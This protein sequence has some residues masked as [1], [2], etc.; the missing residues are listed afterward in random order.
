MHGVKGHIWP[1]STHPP[2]PLNEWNMSP[3]GDQYTKGATVVCPIL[4]TWCVRLVTLL[5]NANCTL[6]CASNAQRRTGS[7]QGKKTIFLDV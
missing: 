2:P 1:Y 4:G 6:F 3:L 7:R 5:A